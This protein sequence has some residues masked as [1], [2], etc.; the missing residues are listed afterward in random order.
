MHLSETITDNQLM[1]ITGSQ[2]I[3]FQ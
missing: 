3:R 2:L 1:C